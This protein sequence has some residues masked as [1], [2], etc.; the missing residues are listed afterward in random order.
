MRGYFTIAALSAVLGLA[1]CGDFPD[2][3]TPQPQAAAPIQTAPAPFAPQDDIGIRRSASAA[4]AACVAQGQNQGMNVQTVVGTREAEG[5]RDVMLRVA[6]GQQVFDV[7][8]R[9]DNTT[10]DARIMTL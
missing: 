3:R 1:A 7:R 4:E 9:Y 5:A 2:L 10:G 6:R 8:C